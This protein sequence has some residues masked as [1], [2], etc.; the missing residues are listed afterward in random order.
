M[1]GIIRF[2]NHSYAVFDFWCCVCEW[3]RTRAICV[4]HHQLKMCVSII[5]IFIIRSYYYFFRVIH[6]IYT[7]SYIQFVKRKK[8]KNQWKCTQKRRR[9]IIIIIIWIDES[10]RFEG[11]DRDQS[12]QTHKCSAPNANGWMLKRMSSFEILFSVPLCPSFQ[13]YTRKAIRPMIT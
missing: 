8:T 12:S 6:F 2:V 10:N 4:C 7:H 5:F 13:V 9:I 3:V 11:A 1:Y